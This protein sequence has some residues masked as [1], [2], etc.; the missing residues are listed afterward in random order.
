[1]MSQRADSNKLQVLV[2]TLADRGRNKHLT[3]GSVTNL[4][5]IITNYLLLC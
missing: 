2:N 5:Q 1:M 4:T 3:G